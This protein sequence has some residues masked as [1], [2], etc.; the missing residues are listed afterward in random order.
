MLPCTNSAVTLAEK[1]EKRVTASGVG[2]P[3][4]SI[5]GAEI[6]NVVVLEQQGKRTFKDQSCHD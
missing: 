1:S 3:A 4:C 5:P 2:A 6:R